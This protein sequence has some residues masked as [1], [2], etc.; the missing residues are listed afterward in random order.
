MKFV[1]IDLDTLNYDLEELKNLLQ[2]TRIILCVN[3]LGNPNN[4]SKI[5]KIIKNKNIILIEDSCEAMG[6]KFGKLNVGNFGIMSSFSSFFSSYI[7]DRKSVTTD[8]KELYHIM[9]SLRAHVGHVIYQ[10]T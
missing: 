2:K 6:A 1:D 9:L 7:N 10:K 3:V 4:F 5:K 8:N